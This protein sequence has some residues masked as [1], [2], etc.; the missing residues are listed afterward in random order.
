MKIKFLLIFL[1]F[2]VGCYQ[3][4]YVEKDLSDLEIE[5]KR[6]LTNEPNIILEIIKEN[7]S[8]IFDTFAEESARRKNLIKNEK[9]FQNPLTPEINKERIVLGNP[10]GSITIVSYSDFACSYCAE[11]NKI[12]QRI[13][14]NYHDVKY[15]YK[16]NILEPN[17]ISKKAAQLFESLGR[18]D[19]KEAW[20]FHDLIFEN[21]GNLSINEMEN[22][23]FS[24]NINLELLQKDIKSDLVKKIIESDIQEANK[25]GFMGVPTFLINGIPLEGALPEKVFEETI[26]FVKRQISRME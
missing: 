1:L 6:I 14:T 11:G 26:D 15:I 19:F 9:Y 4:E 12:I 17:E 10:K 7:S 25:F 2:L 23:A 8:Q 13:L 5:I 20:F 3:K 22:I 21:Q 16:H 18:Q 24:L